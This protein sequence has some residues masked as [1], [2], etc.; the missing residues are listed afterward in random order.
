MTGDRWTNG[1]IG[2]GTA[3]RVARSGCKSVLVVV[4]HV[5]AGTRL[6]DLSPL[7][8]ADH[9]VRVPFTAA[10]S[11]HGTAGWWPPLSRCHTGTSSTCCGVVP[12]GRTRRRGGRDICLDRMAAVLH[13]SIRSVHGARQVQAVPPVPVRV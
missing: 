11:A 1:P 3:S 4:P 8:E 2:L 13:P 5:V 9:R 7:L 10:G 12:R 6:V